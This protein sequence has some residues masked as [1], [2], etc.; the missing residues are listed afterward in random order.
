MKRSV[1]VL[2]VLVALVGAAAAEKKKAPKAA[3]PPPAAEPA[4]SEAAEPAEDPPLTPEEIEAQMP[5]HV[6]GPKLVELG[7][8]IELD[9]PEGMILLEREEAQK[10][11]REGG[12]D[13]ENALGVVV[14]L[15]AQWWAVIEYNDVGYV[16]DSDA[17]QLNANE[18]LD[19]YKQGTQEQNIKRKQLGVPE[20]VLDGWSEMPSYQKAAKH[21]VWGLKG[22]S[23]DGVFIN[24]FT[25]LLG[26]NGYI[27]INLIDSPENI[28]AAKV[29][30]QP[31][32]T[33]TRYKAG[34]RYEDHQDGDK[35][36]GLG[37]RALV[38]GGTGVAV[39]KAA[40]AGIIVKLLLVFKK[41]FIVVF[42]AIGGFFKWLF[43][44]KKDQDTEVPP[45]PPAVSGDPPSV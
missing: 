11:I 13:A 15:D 22:H 16:D 9:L 34:S 38:L 20:L 36:S 8:E 40:K 27:S 5:P 37:L 32:L 31:L 6:K 18:L 21:L 45:D 25:R 39:V 1:G 30:A 12:D 35:S 29:Q 10:L 2:L 3:E 24:Y 33:A 14:R 44:R 41:G 43:G 4:P 26:R 17:D 19:A 28:E 7:H 23:T 42:A